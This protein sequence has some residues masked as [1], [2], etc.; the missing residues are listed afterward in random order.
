MNGAS[1]FPA[2]ILIALGLFSISEAINNYAAAY[3]DAQATCPSPLQ[4]GDYYTP[5]E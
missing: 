1:I 5:E 3:K 4:A 2:A